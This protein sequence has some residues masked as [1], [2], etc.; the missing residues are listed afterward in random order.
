MKYE[1]NNF[2][3]EAEMLWN[4]RVKVSLCKLWVITTT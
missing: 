2:Q 1:S 4:Q 3:F